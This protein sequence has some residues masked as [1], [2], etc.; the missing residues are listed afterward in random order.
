MA[1]QFPNIDPVAI[2]LGPLEVRW[3]ALAYLAGIVVG[4]RYA[5]WLVKQQSFR[6]NVEDIDEFITWLVL[7]IILGGRIGY[8]LVYQSGHYFDDPWEA[9][10]VWH[11]GMSFRWPGSPGGRKYA[12]WR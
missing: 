4:W 12:F 7:G 10:K 11:G 3:Y 9:L 8:V 1:L 6:P 5:L 2:A